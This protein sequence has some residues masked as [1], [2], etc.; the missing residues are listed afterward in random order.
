MIKGESFTRS[1]IGTFDE[2]AVMAKICREAFTLPKPNKKDN[3]M[4]TTPAPFDMHMVQSMIQN[5]K[6][7]NKHEVMVQCDHVSSDTIQL[8]L[9]ESE[10]KVE[11]Q[12]LR[13]RNDEFLRFYVISW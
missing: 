3:D 11:V 9:H 13:S 10:L 12:R 5:A 4:A 2:R 1:W 6:E 8:L 7:K